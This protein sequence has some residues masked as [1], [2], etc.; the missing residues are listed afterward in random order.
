[1]ATVGALLT[2]GIERLRVAGSES[3]RL[4]A[5]LLIG[6][7]LGIDR[8]GV[9]A[10]PEAPVGDGPAQRFREALVRREAGEPVAYIR[11]V[12]EF[13][14]LA[15][16]TDERALIPRPETEHLV[17]LAELEI[18]RRLTGAP[19]PAG[20]PPIRVLDVG[21]GSGV[22]PITLAVLLRARRML[23]DVA[24]TATDI[25]PDALGLARENAV[26]HAVGDR[27][28]FETADLIPGSSPERWD[29]I[30]A[31]LPYV[32]TAAIAGLP[33]ATAFEPPMAL[34]GGADGLEV[35][36]RLLDLLPASLDHDGAALLEIGGDQGADVVAVTAAHLPGWTCVV[37]ADLAGLPRVARIRRGGAS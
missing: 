14:G 26:G 4:D 25:S 32:R 7:I 19:R 1:M 6:H 33:A 29:V 10:H 18:V 9:V 2:E 8:T 23:D 24:L 12:R 16:A 30:V 20:S 22:V 27:V 17:D 21:T 15:F 13:H 11:G 3:A 31:N 35:I 5:E 36:G 37:E 28:A 34:D